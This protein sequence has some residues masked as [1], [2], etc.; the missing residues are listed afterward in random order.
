MYYIFNIFIVFCISLINGL[1][2]YCTGASAVYRR[3]F[4]KNPS[5]SH[6]SKWLTLMG[7]SLHGNIM[8]LFDILFVKRFI[9]SIF[10]AREKTNNRQ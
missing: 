8:Y 10:V 2:K 1:N 4:L 3:I 7:K 9:F 6:H 5:P